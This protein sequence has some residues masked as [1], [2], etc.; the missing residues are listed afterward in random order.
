DLQRQLDSLGQ[1]IGARISVERTL[2]TGARLI[3]LD[4]E[5]GD[6]ER[7]QLEAALRQRPDVRA[8]EPN[9]YAHRMFEPN[10]PM[11]ELQW[12]YQ[13][14]GMGI[15]AVE[16]WDSVDGD[17]YIVAVLDTGQVEHADLE[18]QFV[19]GYDFISDP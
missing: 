10:D 4:R 8:V 17:G 19:A 12:H 2:G 1:Q 11:F 18:G 16:A 14:D 9:G 13:G 7:K 5:V 3:R 6:V 15:N